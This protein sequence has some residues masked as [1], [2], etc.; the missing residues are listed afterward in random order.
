M[1]DGSLGLT[2]VQAPQ[3][4]YPAS[5]ASG[6]NSEHALQ[7]EVTSPGSALLFT[8]VHGT[9]AS[10]ATRT[11]DAAVRIDA[12]LRSL[13]DFERA[14]EVTGQLGLLLDHLAKRRDTA[15]AAAANKVRK[16]IKKGGKKNKAFLKTSRFE[17]A[18]ARQQGLPPQSLSWLS[19]IATQQ[20][21]Q[22]L[23]PR[24][25]T[26]GEIYMLFVEESANNFASVLGKRLGA[27]EK[28]Y[29]DEPAAFWRDYVFRGKDGGWKRVGWELFDM[30][31]DG[32]LENGYLLEAQKFYSD[33]SKA[34]AELSTEGAKMFQEQAA[35]LDK[36]VANTTS[37]VVDWAKLINTDPRK[38]VKQYA[39]VASTIEANFLADKLEDLVGDKVL[40]SM[41]VFNRLDKVAD[42][43]D[44]A[45][46]AT[47]ITE[48]LADRTGTFFA[49]N[50]KGVTDPIPGLGN[51]TPQQ[52]DFISGELDRLNKKFGVDIELQVRPV[53]A[54]SAQIKGGIG[55]VEAIPT[56]NLT[57][58]DLLLGAPE[59]WLGQ[60]AYYKPVKPT[61]LDKKPS[62]D[63]QRIELRYEEKLQEYKQFK[64]QAKDPTGKADKVRKLLKPGGAEVAL[65]TAYKGKIELKQ[66]TKDGAT[67]IEY[68]QLEVNGRPVFNPKDGPRPIVSDF[69]INAAIDSS[70]GRNLPAGIRA[71]VE[72]ELMNS[73]SKAQHEGLIPF[74]F[75]GWTHSGFDFGKNFNPSGVFDLS[76]SDFKN[77]NKHLLMYA[78]EEQ[79]LKFARHYAPKFFPELGKIADPRKLEREYRKAMD[80]ILASFERGKHLVKIT[81]E[82]AVRAGR[83]SHYRDPVSLSGPLDLREDLE[84][85]IQVLALV[86]GHDAGPHQR[87]AGL[88]GRVDRHVHVDAGVVERPPQQHRV[89]VVAH[90]DGDD[91]RDTGVGTSRRRS[92]R[93]PVLEALR[94]VGRVVEQLRE[95]LRA[96]RRSG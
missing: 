33:P 20:R 73:F 43:A 86:G 51:M 67:L 58:D 69:D 78:T 4:G 32:T 7:F 70:T 59:E 93:S 95:Q 5:L 21:N 65:G 77:F 23:S 17:K 16:E 48:R 62:A 60:P 83:G 47:R 24:K 6:A 3:P 74:G 85:A 18:L 52:L 75:H 1:K 29:I 87:A 68:K 37:K 94:Q 80:K 46:D 76:G 88:H 63:R 61:G 11:A 79:A 89:P 56:K 42:K 49:R 72:L 19:K 31:R 54:Y 36:G 55:K 40:Q 84:R 45:L 15:V 96:P 14:G 25:P 30:A 91:R 64:G 41:A 39:R 8:R 13:D 38:M 12:E 90:Q 44:V 34:S 28:K 81:A 22:Q 66:T 92:P 71:Q 2:A 53:N 57:P 82:K 26:W 35:K 27:A 9:D 50:G 10:G